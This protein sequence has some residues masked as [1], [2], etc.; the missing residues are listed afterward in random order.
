MTTLLFVHGTG[1][2]AESFEATFRQI[3]RVL[4]ARRPS[5]A[6]EPCFWG[7]RLGSQ[8]HSGGVSIPRSDATRDIADV[9]TEDDDFLLWAELQVDPLFELRLL[10]TRLESG[11]RG[12]FHPTRVSAGRALEAR[13]RATTTSVEVLALFAAA[14]MTDELIRARETVL[15]SSA[16]APLAETATQVD[17]AWLV[18]MRATLAE[19]LRQAELAGQTPDALYSPSARE[20][21]LADVYR[22]TA[23]EYRSVVGS[24]T[25]RKVVE[26]V[27]A[28]VTAGV[29][30]RRRS[31]TDSAFPFAGDVLLYQRDGSAIRAFVREAILRLEPPVVVLAH[32][33]GGIVCLDLLATE[34]LPVH[35]LITVGTAGPLFHE[36]D[37]MH[38]LRAGEP[39][40]EHFPNWA[41]IYDPRDFLSYIGSGLFNAKITDVEVDNGQPFPR[42]HSAYWWNEQT[43]DVVLERC[44]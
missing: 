43:W 16:F 3:T 21:L 44:P 8:L 22:A 6:V 27:S 10:G 14:G 1:V 38:G 5:L 28:R 4:T 17:G 7:A 9:A 41:N 12:G 40:P 29:A 33:L 32:S 23:E 37:A 13:Y 18:L 31:I 35:C 2:R 26:F 20:K 24:W 42:C 11:E 30:R 19:A 15:I 25:R 36:L 34:P 39:L